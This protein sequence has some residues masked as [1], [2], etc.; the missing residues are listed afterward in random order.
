VLAAKILKVH[1]D[2]ICNSISWPDEFKSIVSNEL[3]L[4]LSF[5]F[6]V[7]TIWVEFR[8]DLLAVDCN[9]SQVCVL[10]ARYFSLLREGKL[11]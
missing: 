8:H 3:Y 6:T 5:I 9:A 7:W 11:W 4:H 1:V 10:N 2:Q